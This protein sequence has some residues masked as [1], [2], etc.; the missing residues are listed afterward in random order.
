MEFGEHL[1]GICTGCHRENLAGGPIAAG[2]PSWAPA[3]NLTPHSDGLAGWIY[4]QFIAAMRDGIR[5]DGTELLMPMSL[6]LPYARRMTDVEMEALWTY[7]QSVPA[8]ASPD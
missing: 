5:P 3:R 6:M 1:A 7:L 4:E 8:V 2:D